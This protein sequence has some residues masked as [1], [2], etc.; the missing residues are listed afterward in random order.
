MSDIGDFLKEQQERDRKRFGFENTLQQILWDGQVEDSYFNDTIHSL[1]A[2][3]TL[4]HT[5]PEWKR[6]F[7]ELRD[8][9]DNLYQVEE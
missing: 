4:T 9:L 5:D 2:L 1:M 8:N 7:E 3:I 6:Q